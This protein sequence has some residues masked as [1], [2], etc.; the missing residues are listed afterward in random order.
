MRGTVFI[1]CRTRI[2]SVVK[3]IRCGNLFDTFC[4]GVPI[5]IKNSK[6]IYYTDSSFYLDRGL[7]NKATHSELIGKLLGTK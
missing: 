4:L 1:Y 5:M 7:S 6:S 2:P 3:D